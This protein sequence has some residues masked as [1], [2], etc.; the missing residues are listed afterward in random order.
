MHSFRSIE[1]RGTAER[2]SQLRRSRGARTS[3]HRASFFVYRSLYFVLVPTD[4]SQT[5][6]HA[7]DT[8]AVAAQSTQKEIMHE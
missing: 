3:S 5:V 8:D 2:R 6:T 1:Q 7:S 4:L